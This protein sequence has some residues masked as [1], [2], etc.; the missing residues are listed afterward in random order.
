V[1]WQFARFRQENL[2]V[3][4]F[5]FTNMNKNQGLEISGIMGMPLLGIFQT[6]AINYRDG[7]VDFRYKR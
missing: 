2:D 6:I 4:S 5:D 1:V 3:A 7:L